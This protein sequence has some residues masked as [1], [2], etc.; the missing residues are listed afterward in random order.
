[1]PKSYMNQID[2]TAKLPEW[3]DMPERE[4]WLFALAQ[5]RPFHC[6]RI[7]LIACVFWSVV[8]P[9]ATR[10]IYNVF[11]GP[12]IALLTV[13]I[14][15]IVDMLKWRIA[16]CRRHRRC[17]WELR[18]PH[19]RDISK[20]IKCI[21]EQRPSSASED[22]LSLWRTAE[23]GKIAQSLCDVGNYP[24][25]AI[26]PQDPLELFMFFAKDHGDIDLDIEFQLQPFFK[27]YPQL[28]DKLIIP[29]LDMLW[30]KRTRFHFQFQ[31]FVELCWREMY[32]S[33]MKTS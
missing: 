32:G 31:D 20:E 19:R 10:N 2:Q 33:A 13:T 8:F 17:I 24:N 21:M 18:W 23:H 11:W 22:Y 1:M 5:K 15:D 26:Y 25:K 12:L 30:I 4:E 14:L 9:V 29:I 7:F 16:V 27:E 3:R 6:G 28:S